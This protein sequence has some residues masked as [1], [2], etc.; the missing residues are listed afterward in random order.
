[1]GY[2]CTFNR[3]N[4]SVKIN[5][6]KFQDISNFGSNFGIYKLEKFVPMSL[7]ITHDSK[8]C[9]YMKIFRTFVQV[10]GQENL[11]NTTVNITLTF[12]L[13]NDSQ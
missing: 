12:K 9:L 7:K 5:G 6:R 13:K 1:M 3:Q 8:T 4:A 2:F 10:Q 11:Q